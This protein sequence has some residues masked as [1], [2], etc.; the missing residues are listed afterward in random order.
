VLQGTLGPD[1]C[2]LKGKIS[3]EHL[4]TRWWLFK[5]DKCLYG[6]TLKSQCLLGQD[7]AGELNMRKMVRICPII[8]AHNATCQSQIT[9]NH[10]PLAMELGTHGYGSF[11]L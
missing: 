5:S 1:L 7:K 2:T 6:I 3:Q 8:I 4:S 9:L 10:D 11:K